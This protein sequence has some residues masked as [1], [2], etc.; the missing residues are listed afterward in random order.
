MRRGK[1][2]LGT[3]VLL[4]DNR[5]FLSPKINAKFCFYE[6]GKL[7]FSAKKALKEAPE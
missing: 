3:G 7:L 1:T 5:P 6:K 2:K 4:S